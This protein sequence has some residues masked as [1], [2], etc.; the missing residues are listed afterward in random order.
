M[1]NFSITRA[2]FGNFHLAATENLLALRYSWI[3]SL[4]GLVEGLL[5]LC[6][7]ANVHNSVIYRYSVEVGMRNR[8]IEKKRKN[9][10]G[11]MGNQTQ[12]HHL[13]LWQEWE[14]RMCVRR[15]IFWWVPLCYKFFNSC[16]SHHLLLSEKYLLLSWPSLTSAQKERA[17]TSPPPPW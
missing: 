2:E 15:N 17:Q 6:V 7:L 16:V 8:Y 12:C 1:G 11:G 10:G 13:V 14:R 5:F 4:S 9:K 3:C